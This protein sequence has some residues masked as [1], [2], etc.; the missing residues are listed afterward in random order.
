MDKIE[1]DVVGVDPKLAVIPA[2][3]RVVVQCEI[4]DPTKGGRSGKHI[5]L[6]LP[7]AEAAKLLALLLEAKK[8]GALP[9][10]DEPVSVLAVPPQ[11]EK[12]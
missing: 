7:I 3:S 12:H 5:H 1:I 10:S 2:R 11:R 4:L 8:N 6:G 9:A